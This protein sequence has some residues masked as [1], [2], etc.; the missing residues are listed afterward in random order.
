[1]TRKNANMEILRLIA[2]EVNQHPDL[3]FGQILRNMDVIIEAREAHSG[4][5]ENTFYEEPHITLERMIDQ[6][7]A[8]AF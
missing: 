5:W 1:M 6:L 8:R 7:K 2:M 4:F 3:R